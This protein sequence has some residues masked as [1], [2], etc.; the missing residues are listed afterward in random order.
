[1]KGVASITLPSA[2]LTTRKKFLKAALLTVSL[3]MLIPSLCA[4]NTIR[5]LDSDGN[6]GWDTSLAIKDG[7]PVISYATRAPV[8]GLLY[9]KVAFCADAQCSSWTLRTVDSSDR[10]IEMTSIAIGA[11]NLPI[12]SYRD[13]NTGLKVAKCNNS[14]CTSWTINQ[15]P[16]SGQGIYSSITIGHDG[17][18]VISYQTYY[19][20]RVLKCGNLSCSSG[21]VDTL[22]KN[23]QSPGY[24]AI[25]IGSDNNPVIAHIWS[26]LDVVWCHNITC[27]A[28]TVTAVPNVGG[29]EVDIAIGQDGNPVISFCSEQYQTDERLKVA[30]CNDITCTTSTVSTVDSDGDVGQHTSIAIGADGLPVISYWAWSWGDLRVA[31]CN[32]ADCSSATINTVDSVGNVGWFTSIAI[33][34]DHNPVISYYDETNKDLKLALCSDPACTAPPALRTLTVTRSGSGI[35]SSDPDGINCGTD[36]SQQYDH[37][38]VVTLTAQPDTGSAFAGWSGACSGTNPECVVT[39]SSNRAVTATFSLPP[40]SHTLTVIKGGP[41][42]VTSLSPGI[43]C[44]SDCSETYTQGA[45]VTLTAVPDPRATFI[46]WSGTCSGTALQCAFTLNVDTTV[47]ATFARASAHEGSIGTEVTVSGAGFG[48]KKGKVRIGEA[49]P[50]IAKDGWADDRIVCLLTKVPPVGGPYDITI[51]PYKSTSSMTLPGAFTVKTPEFVSIDMD[52]GQPGVIIAVNGKFFT[53]KKGKVYIVDPDSGKKKSCKVT[54]WFMD[55]ADGDSRLTFIVPKLS[56]SLPP[57]TYTLRI[58]NKLGIVE[59]MFTVDPSP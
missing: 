37:G 35:V 25:A 16:S 26:G 11:D 56:K 48:I 47:T 5:V 15:I 29:R 8:S 7:L 19:I 54:E 50:S 10:A 31:K 34:A 52:H 22:L 28:S 41:G 49:V 42:T 39:M 20:L 17:L 38:T 21:N 57:G 2:G 45:V 46:G 12:I 43:D 4:G 59:T 55:P 6:V 3:T 40:A 53:T 33:G 36:C 58:S 24:T 9:L 30:K 1:M 13:R 32:N 23:Y 27:T 14:D 44:G 51:T 18:P